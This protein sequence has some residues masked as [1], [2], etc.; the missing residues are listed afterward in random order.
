LFRYEEVHY[1]PVFAFLPT[2]AKLKQS[3]DRS[4]IITIKDGTK[5]WQKNCPFLL[6]FC[7][8]G[9]GRQAE[10]KSFITMTMTGQDFFKLPK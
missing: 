1:P 6:S 10:K 5:Q 8:V 3:E 9:L 7:S 2:S 4:K